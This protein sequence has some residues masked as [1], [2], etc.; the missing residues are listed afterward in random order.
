MVEDKEE[1]EKPQPGLR[2]VVWMVSGMCEGNAIGLCGIL[3]RRASIY[4]KPTIKN[5]Y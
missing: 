2:S 1:K 5:G 4:L 3:A